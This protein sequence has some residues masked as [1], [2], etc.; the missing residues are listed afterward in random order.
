MTHK[1]V[2]E[3]QPGDIIEGSHVVTNVEN[4]GDT[5]TITTEM[6]NPDSNLQQPSETDYPAGQ[7]IKT[8]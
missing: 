6:D 5:V 3:V 4:N 8:G 7:I 1:L 2:D